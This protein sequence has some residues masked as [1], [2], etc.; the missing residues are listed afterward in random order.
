[1]TILYIRTCIEFS[2]TNIKAI[3]LHQAY[4]GNHCGDWFLSPQCYK[5]SVHYPF[6]CTHIKFGR[7]NSCALIPRNF[8]DLYMK[9]YICTAKSSFKI[10]GNRFQLVE[11]TSIM[12]SFKVVCPAQCG[13]NTCATI[14]IMR[15]IIRFIIPFLY[16]TNPLFS[17]HRMLSSYI[18]LNLA[19]AEGCD[20]FPNHVDGFGIRISTFVDILVF[21]G[22]Y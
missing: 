14:A 16:F 1:M 21:S 9:R 5:L 6:Y 8:L 2:W 19:N 4:I 3:Y 12:D 20:T 11:R 13:I 18:L 15:F 10:F 22:H 17:F 7:I